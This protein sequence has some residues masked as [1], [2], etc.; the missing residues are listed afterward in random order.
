MWGMKRFLL[1]LLLFFL[2]LTVDA[3]EAF[4]SPPR[5]RGREARRRAAAA[6]LRLAV[7]GNCKARPA[8]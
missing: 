7:R 2:L 1:M 5:H 4:G 8:P 6:G 3:V